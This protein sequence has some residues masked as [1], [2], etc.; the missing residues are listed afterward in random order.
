V[1]ALMAPLEKTLDE[2]SLSDFRNNSLFHLDCLAEAFQAMGHSDREAMALAIA[3]FG[4]ADVAAFAMLDEWCRGQKPAAFSRTSSSAAW[5]S[6][7]CFG[8]ASGISL[9]AFQFVDAWPT[10]TPMEPVAVSVALSAP[11]L[12]GI[13]V[14]YCVPTGNLRALGIAFLPMIAHSLAAA[15]LMRPFGGGGTF[16]ALFFLLWAPLGCVSVSLTASI[17]RCR[18]VRRPTFP[19]KGVLQ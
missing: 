6:F 17:R 5:W 3:E 19:S 12:A 8:I 2:S 10:A 11:I 9:L 4:P 14:G 1:N 16:L 15:F 7:A 18:P 13:A